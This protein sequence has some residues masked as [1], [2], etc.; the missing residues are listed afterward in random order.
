MISAN[1]AIE[2]VTPLN[3]AGVP[4]A[5]K[6]VLRIAATAVT[7]RLADGA[8]T[9]LERHRAHP[10]DLGGRVSPSVAGR[11]T[12]TLALTAPGVAF[13]GGLA[14][15]FNTARRRDRESFS[16]AG[17]TL[18]LSLPAGGATGYLRVVG[19][20]VAITIAGQSLSTDIEVVDAAGVLTL[21]L[22]N[23]RLELGGAAPLVT[24]SQPTG[25][26]ATIVIA[27]EGVYGVDR[28]RCRRRHP[29]HL[30]HR[31]GLR[32]VQHH[33][34]HTDHFRAGPTPAGRVPA[35]RRRQPHVS[36]A[37]QSLTGDVIFEQVTT[38]TGATVVRSESPTSTSRSARS[39]PRTAPASSSSPRPA[40]RARS[41]VDIVVA[42]GAPFSLERLVRARRST[43]PASR[44][45]RPSQVGAGTVSLDVPAGP[46]VRVAGTGVLLTVMSQQIRADIAVERATSLGADGIVGGGR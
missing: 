46:Y 6:K 37:G 35:R 31:D 18:E 16:I 5:A 25:S 11:I 33:G 36:I 8:L 19:T 45:R 27:P 7:L 32:R 4:D 40:S 12:G 9:A 43:P 41:A 1:I 24:L 22:R 3:A 34:D 42:G 29:G 14:V 20:G 17:E 30:G 28:G 2:S 13:S 44:C 38:T 10:A 21:T 23:T 26:V 15:E 39:P